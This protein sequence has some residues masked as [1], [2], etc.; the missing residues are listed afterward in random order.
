M[1]EEQLDHQRK[2]YSEQLL[3]NKNNLWKS[4]S[5]IK[6]IIGKQQKAPLSKEFIVNENTI[7]DPLATSN[8]RCLLFK[9][10]KR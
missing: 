9:Q 5:I 3:H 2:Y 6:D 10:R 7:T 8:E 4:W 1:F